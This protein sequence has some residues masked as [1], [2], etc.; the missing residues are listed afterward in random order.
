MLLSQL[1]LTRIL[2]QTYPFLMIDEVIEIKKGESLTAI[3]NITGNEWI[4]QNQ[5]F[6][7]EHMPEPL[8]IEAAAQAALVLYA[9]SDDERGN[10]IKFLGKITSEFHDL[11]K[12]SEQIVVT[13]GLVKLMK[14]LGIFSS[15]IH[16]DKRLIA[17]LNLICGVM[18]RVK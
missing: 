10:G 3:K 15:C 13:V 12:I 9:I 18:N 11:P 4:F 5:M 16:A 1:D 17:N 14:N 2:P 6:K 8:I 7:L